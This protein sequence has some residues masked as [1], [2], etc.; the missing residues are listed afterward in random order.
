[1]A[2]RADERISA[3]EHDTRMNE[4]DEANAPDPG[5][6]GDYVDKTALPRNDAPTGMSGGERATETAEHSGLPRRDS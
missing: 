1:M 6:S 3:E 2:E 5:E 4:V